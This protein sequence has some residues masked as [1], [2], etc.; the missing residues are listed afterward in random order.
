MNSLAPRIFCA[1]LLATALSLPVHAVEVRAVRLWSG[2][3]STRVVLD[4]SGR[5]QHSLQ[6]LKNPDRVVLDVAQAR[7]ASGA[8]AA[9][10]GTG[11]VKHVR[12]AR[13]PLGGAA[14]RARFGAAHSSEELSGGAQ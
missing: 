8:R 13:R 1:T 11:A 6:V 4:L 12:M 2:P 10:A 5:A 14:H 7:L 9:P 3:D